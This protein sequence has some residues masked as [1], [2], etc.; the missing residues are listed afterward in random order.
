MFNLFKPKSHYQVHLNTPC[1]EDWD[2][3][4]EVKKG[5][6]CA[7]CSKTVVDFTLMSDQQIIDYI[8]NQ[9]RNTCGHFKTDQLSRDLIPEK[10][11]NLNLFQKVLA[12]SVFIFQLFPREGLAQ[13][14]KK[15]TPIETISTKDSTLKKTIQEH[16][17]ILKGRVFASRQPLP[18]QDVRVE[19]VGT[20][21]Y[22]YTDTNGVYTLEIPDSLLKHGFSLKLSALGYKTQIIEIT[23]NEIGNI[24][25]HQL[26]ELV[27][28]TTKGNSYREGNMTVTVSGG[29]R[30]RCSC[31]KKSTNG[32]NPF[33]QDFPIP[34]TPVFTK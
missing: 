28:V 5:K 3:M 22:A 9:K 34:P 20:S 23:E 33:R 29:C 17:G 32:L 11:K 12:I 6:F 19:F 2:I 18:V 16:T 1:H 13:R 4:T 27:V 15:A 10:N 31:S 14:V 7:S 26:D 25:F 21:H 30:L 8:A 24:L